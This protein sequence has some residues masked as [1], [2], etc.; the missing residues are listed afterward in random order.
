MASSSNT[1]RSNSGRKSTLHGVVE[2]AHLSNI[3]ASRSSITVAEMITAQKKRTAASPD[4]T[5]VPVTR[6]SRT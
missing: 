4:G 3:L 5:V 6:Y 2:S 1:H